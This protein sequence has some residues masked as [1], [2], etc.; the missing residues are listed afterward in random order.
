VVLSIHLDVY[1]PSQTVMGVIVTSKAEEFRRKV[2]ECQRLAY[3]AT[4]QYDR[5]RHLRQGIP[6]LQSLAPPHRTTP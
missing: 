6:R 1:H 5:E 3:K 4:S 2:R